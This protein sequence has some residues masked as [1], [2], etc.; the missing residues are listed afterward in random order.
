M[1]LIRCTSCA[2]ANA[3]DAKVC[4]KCGSELRVPAHLMRCPYCGAPNQRKATV[5]I[6]CDRTLTPSWRRRL[7]GRTAGAVAAAT[8]AL[9]AVVGYYAYPRGLPQYAPRPAAVVAPA[10]APV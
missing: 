9:L 6:R 10:S 7:R 1:A 3:L 4:A 8:L 5:C 2:Y